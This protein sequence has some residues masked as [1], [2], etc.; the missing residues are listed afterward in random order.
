[1]RGKLYCGELCDVRGVFTVMVSLIIYK[2]A[3]FDRTD[4][5]TLRGLSESAMSRSESAP[6]SCGFAASPP[7]FS[8]IFEQQTGF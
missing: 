5:R 8:E 2:E 6:Q 1:M 3:F 4:W 7:E